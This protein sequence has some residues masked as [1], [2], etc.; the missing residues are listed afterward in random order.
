MADRGLVL[1]DGGV[2]YNR[3]R[4]IQEAPVP[5]NAPTILGLEGIP[6]VAMV[7]AWLSLCHHVPGQLLQN[8]DTAAAWAEWGGCRR[9]GGRRP[10]E[11]QRAVYLM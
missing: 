1:G 6:T 8:L 10:V 3:R 11:G 2:P 5:R 9:G 7:F 4:H